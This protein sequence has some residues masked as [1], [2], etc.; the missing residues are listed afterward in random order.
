MNNKMLKGLVEAGAIKAVSI[1]ANG[2][3]VHAEIVTLSGDKKVITTQAGAIKTWATIDSAAKWLKT[4]GL[5][6]MKLEVGQ[7][8]PNQKGLLLWLLVID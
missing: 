6:T 2:S 4:L 7:W 1:I 8:L 5:G 3:V